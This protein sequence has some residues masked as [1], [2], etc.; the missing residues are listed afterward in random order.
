MGDIPIFSTSVNRIH[1]VE[2]D[3]DAMAL[4]VEVLKGG[5]VP[6]Y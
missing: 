4:A 2:A 1:Q 6:R 5:L 3:P